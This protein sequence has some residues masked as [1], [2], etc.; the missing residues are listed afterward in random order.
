VDRRLDSWPQGTSQVQQQPTGLR[1]MDHSVYS[2]SGSVGVAPLLPFVFVPQASHS[3]IDVV[4]IF[5]SLA[6]FIQETPS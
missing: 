4:S 2:F 6:V 5:D 1:H 3:S